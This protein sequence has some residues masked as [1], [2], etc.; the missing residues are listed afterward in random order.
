[1]WLDGRGLLPNVRDSVGVIHEQFLV[2]LFPWEHRK[3][4]LEM[5]M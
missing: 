4:Y 2:L 1:M 3:T 5:I